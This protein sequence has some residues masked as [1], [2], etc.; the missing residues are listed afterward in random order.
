M[1]ENNLIKIRYHAAELADSMSVAYWVTE[2]NK[3]Y[4]IVK[5]IE[6][7]AKVADLMGYDIT[8]REEPV[9]TEAA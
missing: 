2:N 1:N 3:N 4:H 7:F 9:E 8:K 6:S 5:A